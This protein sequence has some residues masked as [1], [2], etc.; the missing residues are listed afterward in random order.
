MD[1]LG[2][3][4][5]VGGRWAILRDEIGCIGSDRMY[6]VKHVDGDRGYRVEFW[7]VRAA[8]KFARKC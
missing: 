7:R 6:K 5:P 3:Y 2:M 8:Q 1:R 4:L